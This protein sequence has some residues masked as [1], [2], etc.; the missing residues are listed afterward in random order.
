MI[1]LGRALLL[2]RALGADGGPAC[3]DGWA[4]SPQSGGWYEVET[5]AGERLLAYR[6]NDDGTRGLFA[7]LG[8]AAVLASIEASSTLA[9]PAREAWRRRLDPGVLPY[10]RRWRTY[11]WGGLARDEE[12]TPQPFASV[13][14]LVPYGVALPDPT[15]SALPW[16][17]A[18]DGTL[19][20]PAA[21]AIRVDSITL[22]ALA[23]TMAG[24][25]CHGRFEA[26]PDPGG[27]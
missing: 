3:P 1:S 18:S 8:D 12:G 27:P 23:A 16:H 10:M 25:D 15:V 11:R 9:L 20:T 2:V 7:I 24:L 19:T 6:E 22:P 21:A 17:L 26:E 13:S 5:P 14:S 4:C